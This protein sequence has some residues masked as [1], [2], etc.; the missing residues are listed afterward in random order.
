MS[1]PETQD[2]IDVDYNL[3]WYQGY[4]S[5]V[6]DVQ[7]KVGKIIDLS[8]YL[9]VIAGM[10]RG[11]YRWQE[12]DTSWYF[13]VPQGAFFGAVLG[14]VAAFGARFAF[15]LITSHALFEKFQFDDYAKYEYVPPGEKNNGGWNKWHRPKWIPKAAR[16]PPPPPSGYDM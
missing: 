5:G 12:Y 4:Q 9:V 16:R 8:T 7:A 2:K 14:V 3:G 11:L 15:Y 13:G 10:A 6:S 1:S